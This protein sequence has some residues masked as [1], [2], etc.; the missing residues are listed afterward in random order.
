MLRCAQHD[1]QD[2]TAITMRLI[3]LIE[4]LRCAQHDSQDSGPIRSQGK[5]SLQMPDKHGDC[6]A[7]HSTLSILW[8]V[9]SLWSYTSKHKITCV[10]HGQP[11][12]KI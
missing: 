2:Q 11:H 7:M 5:S 12:D 4:M 3:G 1:S 8:L 6:L 9:F 10:K